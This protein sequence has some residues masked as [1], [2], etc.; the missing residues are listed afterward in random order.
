MKYDHKISP[1]I[2]NDIQNGILSLTALKR[3][4][5]DF[6]IDLSEI[7]QYV[8][9]LESGLYEVSDFP[10]IGV[11][12]YKS[13]QFFGNLADSIDSLRQDITQISG[14]ASNQDS[15]L[16]QLI[17]DADRKTNEYHNS[18]NARQSALEYWGFIL[19]GIGIVILSLIILIPIVVIKKKKTTSP[20]KGVINKKYC[21]KC[22]SPLSHTVKYCRKCG[23]LS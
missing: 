1:S 5:D 11:T 9:V 12:I 3:Q 8:R 22:G 14:A 13:A 10:I 18:W 7:N 19:L 17:S 23:T 6:S 4:A 2:E 15:K 16:N 20:K 21:R